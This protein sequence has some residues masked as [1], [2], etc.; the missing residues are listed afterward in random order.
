MSNEIIEGT[1]QGISYKISQEVLDDLVNHFGIS[2]IFEIQRGINLALMGIDI[3]PEVNLIDKT[4]KLNIKYD[5]K[6]V[7]N[8]ADIFIKFREQTGCSKMEAKKLLVRT[9]YDYD[10]AIE[11]Y[12]ANDWFY[13]TKF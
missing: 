7:D 9:N 3:K 1:H 6:N 13:R 2:G 4:A 11:L 10:K 8:N 5:Q 12:R